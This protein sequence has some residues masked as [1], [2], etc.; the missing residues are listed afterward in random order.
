[1]K[2]WTELKADGKAEAIKAIW[3][4]DISAAQIAANFHGASRNAVIGF[5]NRHKDK[6]LE[7]PLQLPPKNKPC[8]WHERRKAQGKAERQKRKK[9]VVRLFD[10]EPLPKPKAPPPEARNVPLMDLQARE[11]RFATNDADKGDIHLFCGC[12]TEW[13]ES[14][15]EYHMQIAWK[16]FR[17]RDYREAA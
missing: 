8:L 17:P 16:P 2:A 15:C 12:R 7:Y 13:N 9:V 14:Y 11:C 10:S 4:P 5:Y 1:M 3:E 6:L